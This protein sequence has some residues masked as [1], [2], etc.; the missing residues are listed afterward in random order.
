MNQFKFGEKRVIE[1]DIA[2][3]VYKAPYNE[4][5]IR[6][7]RAVMDGANAMLK[8]IEQCDDVFVVFKE[9]EAEARKDIDFIL[10]EGSF[11]KIFSVQGYDALEEMDLLMFLIETVNAY[12]AKQAE[13]KVEL[14]EDQKK[15]VET[16]MQNMTLPKTEDGNVLDISR[17]AT[18]Y[19]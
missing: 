16:A 11:E 2:G 17:R 3:E 1:F 5:L 6:G 4:K 9:V 15:K 19:S 18:P 7:M 8:K 10:G 13:E 14:T 12:Q